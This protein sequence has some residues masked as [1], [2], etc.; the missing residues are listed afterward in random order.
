MK[1]KWFWIIL[2]AISMLSTIWYLYKQNQSLKFEQAKSEQNAAAIKDILYKTRD[3]LQTMA[4]SVENLNLKNGLLADENNKV[5]N[6]Y[7]ALRARYDIAIDSINI[8]RGLAYGHMQ[9]DS[10]AIVTFNGKKSIA[11][12]DGET[13]MN[14]KTKFSQLN[15]LNLSFETIDVRSELYLDEVDNIWKMR[16]ISMTPGIKLR[17]ISTLDDETFK[18]IKGVTDDNN[19]QW[20]GVGG[21][22]GTNLFAPGIQIKPSRWEFGAHYILLDNTKVLNKWYDRVIISVHYFPF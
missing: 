7:R 4:V 14:I 21:M 12:Y 5:K 13:E 17:G 10:L 3:S 8:L 6:Q 1:N 19:T 9:G 11:T 15:Y 18:K 16:T 22:F 2:I 20:F